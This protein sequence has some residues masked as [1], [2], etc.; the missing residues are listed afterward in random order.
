M[1]INFTNAMLQ[2]IAQ[3]VHETRIARGILDVY[4]VAETI[5]LENINDNVAREDII[6]K[7]VTLASSAFV[8]ILFNRGAF[9]SERASYDTTVFLTNESFLKTA[10]K[11]GYVH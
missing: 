8:P 10:R 1:K 2:T 7:L 4:Q 5:R 6:E 11:S 9:E 3:H